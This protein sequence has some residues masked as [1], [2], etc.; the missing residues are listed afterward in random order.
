MDNSEGSDEKIKEKVVNL[1]TSSTEDIK[2]GLTY[3]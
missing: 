2:R 1:R 3:L